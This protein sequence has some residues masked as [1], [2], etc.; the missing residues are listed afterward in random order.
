MTDVVGLADAIARLSAPTLLALIVLASLR[1]WWYTS[2]QHRE[3]LAQHVERYDA[4][5]ED[6]DFWRDVAIRATSI[7]EHFVQERKA[8]GRKGR[9]REG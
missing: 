5:E 3:I 8:D 7:G 9:S 4:L 6:R 1:G 2:F